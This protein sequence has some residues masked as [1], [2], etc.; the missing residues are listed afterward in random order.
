MILK[1]KRHVVKV[2]PSECSDGLRA[3]A[4]AGRVYIVEC[5]KKSDTAGRLGYKPNK[6][7]SRL[8]VFSFLDDAQIVSE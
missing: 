8:N 3:Q 6:S 1:A 2:R 5:I 7:T 4:E